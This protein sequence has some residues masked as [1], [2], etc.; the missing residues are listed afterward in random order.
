MEHAHPLQ[1]PVPCRQFS[2]MCSNL[3]LIGYI[4]SR[5]LAKSS[6]V[7]RRVKHPADIRHLHLRDKRPNMEWAGGVGLQNVAGQMSK[8]PFDVMIYTS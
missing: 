7:V 2:R 4:L 1:G 5:W 6:G 3:S 8:Y